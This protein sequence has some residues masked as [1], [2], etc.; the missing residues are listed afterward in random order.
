MVSNMSTLV[1]EQ[2]HIASE[3]LLEVN[4]TFEQAVCAAQLLLELRR[5]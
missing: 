2:A 5:N 4:A 3:R 1:M